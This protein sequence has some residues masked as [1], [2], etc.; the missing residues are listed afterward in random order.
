M[1]DEQNK[2]EEATPFKL[3]EARRKGQVSKSVEF[4][5]AA[6]LGVALVT[7][8][9]IV[10]ATA[11]SVCDAIAYW[12]LHA[13]STA[14]DF[15]STHELMGYLSSPYISLYLTVSISALLAGVVAYYLHAP[16]VLSFEPIKPQLSKLNPVS[17]F[18]RIFSRKTLVEFFKTIFKFSFF[19][20]GI[21]FVLSKEVMSELYIDKSTMFAVLTS[22]YRSAQFFAGFLFS[23]IFVFAV[24]DLWHTR[25]DY[26]RQMKMSTRD[27]KDEYKR[28]D[29]D[30]EVKSRRK[31]NQSELL[32]KLASTRSV[33]DADVVIVNTTHFAV[34]LQ[35]RP[36][37]MILPVVLSK[38]GGLLA[39]VIIAR[40]RK[41]NVPVL[42]R[43]RLARS[44]V[45]DVSIGA[46]INEVHRKDV[47]AVY[48]WIVSLPNN[49]VLVS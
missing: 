47:V 41:E 38:G 15:H 21:C 6:S 25:K 2:S 1:A 30:P 22:W 35:F 39:R 23:I 12:L 42:R 44:L 20:L 43:P 45:K 49:K 31:K 29:G 14:T 46:P 9:A 17:G 13:G 19:I 26:S 4:T 5:G 11:E 36:E 28:R 24:F 40:A 3:E 48:R 34:A 32:A 16:P 27:V 33:N 10:P 18:K 37:K 7:L 8:F